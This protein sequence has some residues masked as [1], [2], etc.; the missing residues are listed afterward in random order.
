[1]FIYKSIYNIFIIYI[2]HLYT[3]H[4]YTLSLI[5]QFHGD[6]IILNIWNSV[7]MIV[8]ISLL[9]NSNMC[10]VLCWY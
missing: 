5:F 4:I 7:I 3:F 2:N 1:M 8:S 9:A 10:L 6:W